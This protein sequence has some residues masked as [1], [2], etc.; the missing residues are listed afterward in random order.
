M[1]PNESLTEWS[2]VSEG[3]WDFAEWQVSKIA[4]GWLLRELHGRFLWLDSNIIKLGRVQMGCG[5]KVLTGYP[6]F[7]WWQFLP[8][9]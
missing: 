7:V 8:Y 5:I 6:D 9:H 1:W 2:D 3:L 4:H